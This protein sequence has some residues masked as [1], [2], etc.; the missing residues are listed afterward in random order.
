M[1]NRLRYYREYFRHLFTAKTRHGTHSP[2]V[3]RL[4]EEVIYPGRL[5][6]EPMDK[7]DR[8]VARLVQHVGEQ[9]VYGYLPANLTNLTA[10]AVLVLRDI[11]VSAEKRKQWQ[12]V[13]SMDAVTVT[14]DLFY[15]GLVF[16]HKGQAKEHFRIRYSHGF[17]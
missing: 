8:L 4:L 2:F 10:D 7:V 1:M 9:R 6:A 11:H 16:F 15:V 3:Y 12:A 13:Q 14:I 5:A 17:I